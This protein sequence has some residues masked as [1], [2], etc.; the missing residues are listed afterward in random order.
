MIISILLREMFAFQ[1]SKVMQGLRFHRP[2]LIIMQQRNVVNFEQLNVVKKINYTFNNFQVILEHATYLHK[3]AFKQSK[4]QCYT[5][6]TKV[7]QFN[8]RV[9]QDILKIWGFQKHTGSISNI[10]SRSNA[11]HN[12]NESFL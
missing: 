7:D 5:S 12:G 2:E 1:E 4:K 9:Y 11:H 6:P 10:T 8:V 3:C